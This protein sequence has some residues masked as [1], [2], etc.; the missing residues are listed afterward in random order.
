[1]FRPQD[2]SFGKTLE[3]SLFK[4]IIDYLKYLLVFPYFFL[5]FFL[6][7]RE[8]VNMGTLGRGETKTVSLNSI[9]GD[10]DMRVS[11]MG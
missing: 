6:K 11:A 3:I 8:I 4:N 2:T 10:P 5:P 7:Q 1:M 9:I